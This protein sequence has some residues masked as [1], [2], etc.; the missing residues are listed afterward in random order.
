VYS[1]LKEAFGVQFVLFSLSLSARE[2]NKLRRA[3][4]SLEERGGV[5]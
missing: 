5:L 3:L 1:V 2:T 4:W